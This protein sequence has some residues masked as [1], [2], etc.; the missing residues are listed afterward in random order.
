MK[1]LAVTG[2][3][4]LCLGVSP[5]LKAE[6]PTLK[7]VRIRPNLD[8]EKLHYILSTER[9]AV[10]ERNMKLNEQQ[11]EVFWGV[12]HRYEQG[13]GTARSESASP[14]GHVYRQV[15]HIDQ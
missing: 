12:Y 13:E 5:A 15:C 9:K 3:C 8:M 1:P 10:F 6:E 7:V 4:L 2:L 14:A 11:S